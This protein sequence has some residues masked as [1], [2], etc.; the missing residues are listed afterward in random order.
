[1]IDP[2]GYVLNVVRADPAVAAITTTVRGA[3]L[4]QDDK[5]PCVVFVRNGVTRSRPLQR[6]RLIARCYGRDA[7]EAAKLYGAVSDVLAF[8]GPGSDATRR[9]YQI[10][11]E[12]GGAAQSD[13]DTGW[14][15]ESAVYAVSAAT[16]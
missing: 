3:E 2:L 11:E 8:R 9:V 5:P 16:T 12:S 1:V 10:I 13:P 7:I 14:P 4:K 6:V 15:F